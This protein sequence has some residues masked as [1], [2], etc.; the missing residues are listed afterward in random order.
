MRNGTELFLSSHFNTSYWDNIS[1]ELIVELMGTR[2]LWK[3][4]F[5][6][7]ADFAMSFTQMTR[8]QLGFVFGRIG[9]I[10]IG[11]G[12][13]SIIPMIVTQPRSSSATCST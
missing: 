9:P 7:D 4:T 13:V 12:L 8:R 6:S 1:E 3:Y 11:C 2:M 10:L 5:G